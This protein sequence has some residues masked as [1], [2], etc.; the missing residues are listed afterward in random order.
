[1]DHAWLRGGGR[2]KDID[3]EVVK[4][5]EEVIEFNKARLAIGGTLEALGLGAYGSGLVV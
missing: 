2:M 4:S 1:M 3:A 5:M